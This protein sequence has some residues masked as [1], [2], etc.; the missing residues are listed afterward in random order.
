[1]TTTGRPSTGRLRRRRD[2]AASRTA[3][4]TA[5]RACFSEDSYERVGVRDIATRAGVT[6]ALVIRYFG[7]KERL[8]AEALRW[9][10]R[11]LGLAELLVGDLEQLGARLARYV[12]LE[13]PPGPFLT[14]VR[15]APNAQAAAVVREIT[16]EEFTVP[17]ARRLAGDHAALRASIRASIVTALLLGLA[18]RYHVLQDG[19]ATVSEGEAVVA[20][21]APALQ[22]YLTG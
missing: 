8:F 11:D 9:D 3:I 1:M 16:E 12:V 14:I 15:V 6:A 10:L 17:L 22:S 20:L 4:L 2:A 18:V 7:S 5:A 21:V 13:A 19:P